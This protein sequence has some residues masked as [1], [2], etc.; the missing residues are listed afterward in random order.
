MYRLINKNKKT[1][2]KGGYIKHPHITIMQYIYTNI[3]LINPDFPNMTKEKQD[4]NKP[5]TT[6]ELS[7]C[8]EFLI[9]SLT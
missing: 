7:D 3:G 8:K 4:V 5:T 2:Q 6:T 1:T 9:I